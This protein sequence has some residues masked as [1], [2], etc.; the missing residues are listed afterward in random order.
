MEVS[1]ITIKPHTRKGIV[2]ICCNSM[3]K[4]QEL[5]LEANMTKAHISYNPLYKTYSIACVKVSTYM[6]SILKL[7]VKPLC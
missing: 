7:G 6:D 3:V 1:N 5:I 4:L 2:Y